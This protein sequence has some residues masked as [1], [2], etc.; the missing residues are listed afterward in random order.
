[1]SETV[2]ADFIGRFFAPGIAGEPPTGRVLLSRRRLVLAGDD[3]KETIPL[4]AV[5]DVKV[6]QVPPEMEGYFNDTVTVAYRRDD[7][8]AVA[9]IEGKDTNIDRFATVLF[10]VLLNGT[11]ALTRHPAKV[12]GRVVD[13]ET[14]TARL[15]V[16][17]G[18]LAFDDRPD[19]FSVE[20]TRVVSVERAD[21][22][23][24]NGSHP[25]ISFRHVED[26]TAVTTQVG[27]TSNRLTNILGRYVRLRYADV[28][29]ELEDVDLGEEETEVLVAAYSAGPGVSLAKVVDIDPQRLTMLLNGLIDEGLLV[30]TDEGT[31]LTAK[32]RVIVDQRIESVNT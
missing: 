29:E 27:M 18:S 28:R 5:F 10:K 11:K 9:A 15:D 25:V 19:P 23:L 26:G 14:H 3:Y 30:D 21:R 13:S 6:G 17:R 16:T 22:D 8:R 12:G 20:L 31:Q 1:M 7:G 32:G 4:S 24:G 2:V